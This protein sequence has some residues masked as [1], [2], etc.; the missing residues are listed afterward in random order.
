MRAQIRYPK[1]ASIE[2][3]YDYARSI[4]DGNV[5]PHLPRLR[6]LATGLP[7]CVEFGVRRG[8]SSSALLLGADHVISYDITPLPEAKALQQLAGSRWDYRIASSL[9]VEIP[10]CDLLFIDSKHTFLHCQAE[11]DRHAYKA[12]RYLVFH[13][14]IWR[15]S[16]GEGTKDM[17]ETRQK[18]DKKRLA[19]L[20]IR[21]AIDNLMIRDR[22]W[23]LAAHYTDAC[24]LLVLER[25]NR[26]VSTP[27]P[28]Q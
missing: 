24:G 25:L 13:D 14:S 11:L 16:W 9:D 18:D 23:F 5:G 12:T 27:V 1:L 20:G 3:H 19:A 7:L 6:A 22:T 17:N 21:P 2:A 15:G 10:P 28:V 8:G 26:S 4:N